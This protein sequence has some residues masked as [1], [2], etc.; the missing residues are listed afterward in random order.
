MRARPAAVALLALALVAGCADDAVQDADPVR[1]P[2]AL[3]WAEDTDP[4]LAG[5]EIG[6][7]SQEGAFREIL[8]AIAVETLLAAGVEVPDMEPS[9]SSQEVR[10]DQLAGLVDL[11]WETTGTGWLALLREIGPSEDPDQLYQDVR[12][13]DLEENGIVWLPPAPADAGL[14]IVAEPD[15]IE[16]T[17]IGTTSELADALTGLEDGVRVCVSSARR[18]LDPAGV[19]ALAD[20][21]GVRIRPRVVRL[22]PDAELFDLAEDGRRCP[23][24]LV[25]KL[26]PRLSSSDLELL[27]DDLGAFVAQQPAVT[28]RADTLDL[29]PGLDDLFA[30]VA[31]ALDTDTLREL[32]SQ[33]EDADRTPDAVARD[34]LVDAGFAED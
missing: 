28:V 20:A 12:D 8:G 23:F 11:A 29:A 10:E 13:E 19:A 32:V 24:T 3:N 27:D 17:E 15:V 22:H 18:P 2:V 25:E 16:E 7:G 34:W 31:E 21:A 9:G 26:D 14:G 1:D 6:V 5:V 33:V 30:P 4:D